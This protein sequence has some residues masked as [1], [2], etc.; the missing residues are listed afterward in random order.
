MLHAF[1]GVDGSQPVAS[2]VFDKAGNLYGTSLLE[3]PGRMGAGTFLSSL[4][5]P[6]EHGPRRF[7][8]HSMGGTDGVLL[9]ALRSTLPEIFTVRP[10]KEARA[11]LSATSTS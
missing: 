2:L 7:C 8:L 11:A 10:M 9:A 1:D 5:I 3:E 4:L 6:M